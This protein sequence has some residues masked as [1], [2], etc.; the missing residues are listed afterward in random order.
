MDKEKDTPVILVVENEEALNNLIQKTLQREGF[1]TEGALSGTAALVRITLDPD[2]LLLLDY[3]LKDMTAKDLI[4]IL[5]KENIELPFIVATGQGDEVTAVKMM[6]LGARDYVMKGAGLIK[7]LPHVIRKVVNDLEFENKHREAGQALKESENKF[8]LLFNQASDSIFL[9]SLSEGVP[10]IED[11]NEAAL[12]LHG[13]SREELIGKPIAFL[14]D[15]ES[16]KHIPE[17][18]SKLMTEEPVKFEAVH[19]R[20]DGTIF[21]LEVSAQMREISG[22]RYTL[23]IERDI[24][25]RKRVEEKLRDAGEKLQRTFDSISDMVSLHDRNFKIVKVNKAMADFFGKE[26]DELIGRYC[27]EVFHNRKDPWPD[28]PHMSALTLKKPVTRDVN[29]PHIGCALEISASPVFD[30]EGN[31]METVHIAKD[32]SVRKRSEMALQESERR[33]RELVACLPEAVAVYQ[34]GEIIYINSAGAALFGAAA[35]AQIIGKPADDRTHPDFSERLKEDILKSLKSSHTFSLLE[36]KMLRLDGSVFDA[37]V[38]GSAATFFGRPAAQ[39]VIRDIS[40]RKKAEEEL[41][42]SRTELSVLYSVSSAMSRTIELKELLDIILETVTGIEMFDT[43][44]KGGIFIVEGDRMELISHLGHSGEFLALHNNMRIG[45][46][47]CGLAA[48]TGEIIISKDSHHDSRHTIRYSE[49]P[50]HGHI[51]IPL[52]AKDKVTGVLYLYLSADFEIEESKLKLLETISGQ[53]GVAIEN[54]RLYEE[55]KRFSLHDPLTGLANRRYIDI[56][57]ERNFAAAK[58]FKK[59]FSIIMADIDHFKK[60]NDTY[61]HIAGD[62]ILINVARI[63]EKETREVDLISRYGGEEFLILL[64]EADMTEARSV[65]EHKRKAVEE[66]AG[67]TLSLGVASYSDKVKI[68]EELIKKA[69]EALYQAKQ[70]GRNR[71]EVFG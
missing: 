71:V 59:P 12:K 17:R 7:V 27:Y 2:L 48:E 66:A 38:S 53:L 13:Y 70:K 33:Y 23:A 54:A 24:T 9:M 61:G 25:E 35:P 5:K 22:K 18:V 20:K 32:I 39:L 3:E 58:R 8:R 31:V 56:V 43:Q 30:K 1:R 63:L 52:K 41:Q 62:K 16:V 68:A 37:Y 42:K 26:P 4:K 45:D 65:A 28:C 34:N 40:A 19:L 64:S 67:I 55:T 10:I 69:D 50:S 51:I 47:L 46:C 57:L 6:K 60:Y 49:M 11:V 15:P 21:P 36:G 29:D 44:K 14:N